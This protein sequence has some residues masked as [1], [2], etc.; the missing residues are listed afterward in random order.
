MPVFEICAGGTGGSRVQ[1]QASFVSICLPAR[2]FEL[3]CS[4][5]VFAFSKSGGWHCEVRTL[6]LAS[7]PAGEGVIFPKCSR[8]PTPFRCEQR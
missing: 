4:R 3:G 5:L 6:A 7:L 2:V 8:L 1:E